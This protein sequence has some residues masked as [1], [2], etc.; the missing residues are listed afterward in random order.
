MRPRSWKIPEYDEAVRKE[1]ATLR[2]DYLETLSRVFITLPRHM[3]VE[4]A[5][6]DSIRNSYSYRNP[7]KPGYM[8]DQVERV[9]AVDFDTQDENEPMVGASS[10]IGPAGTGKSRIV[11][12]CLVRGCPQLIDHYE[13]QGKRLGLRQI[14]WIYVSCAHDG[15]VKSL[16]EDIARVVD[17]I[18]GGGTDYVRRVRNARTEHDKKVELLRA[19]ALH[20]V[21]LIVIDEFQNICVGR[22][23]ERK[24]LARFLVGLM[25]S[26]ST[27]IMLTGTPE[28][29]TEVVKDMPLV[30][31]TIGEHGQIEWDRITDADEWVRF[32]NGIWRYQYTATHTPLT[33]GP[34]SIA[35]KIH[36]LSYGIP[37]LAVK[38]YRM[39]QYE[40]IGSKQNSNEKIDLTHFDSV[41]ISR[42]RLARSLLPK[43]HLARSPHCCGISRKTR[44]SFAAMSSSQMRARNALQALPHNQRRTHTC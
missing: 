41:S 21:G 25:E 17:T 7:M 29:Q 28:A 43:D 5:I 18:L 16:C 2:K 31:R 8:L 44:K 9:E 19:L 6:M 15:S 11:K 42:M 34:G 12:R 20:A 35:D 39:T 3:R 27:R 4:E 23:V 32:L 38:L 24:R 13:Y 22:H 26:T 14:A 33:T 36:T 10:L 37:D 40:I 1:A 30:R